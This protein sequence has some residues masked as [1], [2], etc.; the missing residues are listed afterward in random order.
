MQA[1][2]IVETIVNINRVRRVSELEKFQ[3]QLKSELWH[4]LFREGLVQ[5]LVRRRLACDRQ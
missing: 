4:A 1:A 2:S 5:N 3:K